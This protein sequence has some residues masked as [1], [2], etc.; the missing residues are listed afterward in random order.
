LRVAASAANLQQTLSFRLKA[1]IVQAP[2]NQGHHLL[3]SR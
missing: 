2:P 1:M 3:V